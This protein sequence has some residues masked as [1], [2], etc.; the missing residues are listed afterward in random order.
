MRARTLTLYL[1]RILGRGILVALAAL[2]MLGLAIELREKAGP[3]LAEGGGPALLRFALYRLPDTALSVAPVALLAG[4]IL[5]FALL[6]R[7]GEAVI[8][9]AAGLST[10]QIV[11]ALLPLG[12]LLGAGLHL[13][14]DRVLPAAEAAQTAEF[15][16]L[17][18][19]DEAASAVWLRAPGWVLRGVPRGED[20]TRLAAV[21]LFSLDA[22]GALVERIDAAA[23]YHQGGVWRLE[24]TVTTDTE[25]RGTVARPRLDWRSSL[26][27]ADVLV[28]AGDARALSRRDAEAALSGERLSTRPRSYYET[29]SARALSLAAMPMVLILLASPVVLGAGRTGGA[30]ARAAAFAALLGLVFVVG[31]G[32]ALSLGE[33]GLMAP[34]AAAWAPALIALLIGLWSILRA[35]T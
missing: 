33:K 10:L 8:L 29:R 26:R 22:G 7:R 30:L 21:T 13:L 6:A 5:G 19:E 18:E 24:D 35:E 31:E 9:R 4:A 3:V 20:G 27:P 15:G 28:L 16:A 12:L 23:A 25:T 32:V 34:D 11:G 2:T 17:G 14:G 1:S